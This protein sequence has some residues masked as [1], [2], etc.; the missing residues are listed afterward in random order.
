VNHT[1]SRSG[2]ENAMLRLLEG[3]PSEVARA[4]ACPSGGGLKQTL[5]DRGITQFDLPAV[6]LSVNLHPIQTGRGLARLV[7]SRVSLRRSA[8]RFRAD[9]IHANRVT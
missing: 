9:V 2:A 7:T 5:R 3:I 4:V 8:Q 1:G 6:E